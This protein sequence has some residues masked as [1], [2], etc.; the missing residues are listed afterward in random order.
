MD[1]HLTGR[2]YVVMAVLANILVWIIAPL[3]LDLF[4]IIYFLPGVVLFPA[5]LAF[6]AIIAKCCGCCD[7]NPH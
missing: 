1:G 7:E 4:F 5:L 2:L 3:V 6:G